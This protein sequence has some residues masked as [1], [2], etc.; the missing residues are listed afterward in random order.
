MTDEKIAQAT[1]LTRVLRSVPKVLR[2]LDEIAQDVD[3]VRHSIEQGFAAQA[4][5]STTAS[6]EAALELLLE[7]YEKDYL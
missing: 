2:D 4:V 6:M 7:L 1:A 5:V 3:N